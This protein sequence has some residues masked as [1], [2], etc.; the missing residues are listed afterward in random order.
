MSNQTENS[1]VRWLAVLM[2]IAGFAWWIYSWYT[3]PPV[4]ETANLKYIQLLM[5]AV[6]SKQPESVARVGQ[7]IQQRFDSGEMSL[8]EKQSL[9]RII[10]MTTAGKWNEA[11][12]ACF[13]LAEGQLN[14]TRKPNSQSGHSHSHSH[15]PSH[16]GGHDHGKDEKPK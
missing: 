2:V 7:S 5:T 14:R 15:D 9:E 6:S 11:Y 13:R 1:G 3:R 12:Q 10:A 8:S 16:D 4:I